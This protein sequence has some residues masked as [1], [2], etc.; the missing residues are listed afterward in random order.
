MQVNTL[1]LC[2]PTLSESTIRLLLMMKKLSSNLNEEISTFDSGG[3]GYENQRN[4]DC[5]KNVAALI[6]LATEIAKQFFLRV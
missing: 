2:P 6:S 4:V 3:L 5:F 1:Q